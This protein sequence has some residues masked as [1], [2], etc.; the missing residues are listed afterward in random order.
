MKEK[1][2]FLFQDH[3]LNFF[4][5]LFDHISLHGTGYVNIDIIK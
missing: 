1:K 4:F 5:S 2:Y 3:I